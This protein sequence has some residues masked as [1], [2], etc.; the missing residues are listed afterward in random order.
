MNDQTLVTEHKQYA[1]QLKAALMSVQITTRE[2]LDGANNLLKEVK[3]RFKALDEREKSITK[4]LNEGLKSARDLFRDPK[5]ELESVEQLLKSA[6]SGYLAEEKAK[7]ERK[8]SEASRA[9]QTGNVMAGREAVQAL[10]QID[11]AA[12]QG[13]STRDVLDFEIVAP[14]QVDRDL[15]SP[16]SALIRNRLKYADVKNPPTLSGLRVFVKTISTSR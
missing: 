3:S 16:D 15:C 2:D 5:N 1:V 14:G 11:T 4:P 7:Q 9:F 6:I 8:A 10:T 12:P 13:F